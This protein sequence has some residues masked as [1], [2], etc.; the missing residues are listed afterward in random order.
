MKVSEARLILREHGLRQDAI[1]KLSRWEIVAAVRTLS[2]EKTKAGEGG[3]CK[4]S[5]INS[6]ITEIQERYMKDCQ[7]IFELQ[8][9][10]LNSAQVLSTDDD[11]STESED[12]D[13]EELGRNLEMLLSEN[14]SSTQLSFE[15]E[16]QERRELLEWIDD[17]NKRELPKIKEDVQVSSSR[18]LRLTRTIKDENGNEFSRVEIVRKPSVIDLY[19]KIRTTK[20][21]KFIKHYAV[22][23]EV[24]RQ[25]M[26]RE[27][28]NIMA[29]LR[30]IKKNE[31][32]SAVKKSIS[33]EGMAKQDVNN[34]LVKMEADSDNAIKTTKKIGSTH[35]DYLEYNR[36]SKRARKNPIVEFSQI[37]DNIL[38]ELTQVAQYEPFVCPVSARVYGYSYIVKK[39]MDIQSMR[40][41]LRD[42]KYSC[43]AEFLADV[44]QIVD[45]SKLFNGAQSFLTLAA[46]Q[47]LQNCVDKL[48]KQE[49]QLMLLELAI[50]SGESN[51][52]N[53]SNTLVNNECIIDVGNEGDCTGSMNIPVMIYPSQNLDLSHDGSLVDMEFSD[54]DEE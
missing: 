23:D 11:D 8:N 13:F 22:Q 21:D 25:A 36:T 45:N 50:D 37:C 24:I 41:K 2:T 27:K 30:T 32:I 46:E 12:S 3:L 1:K 53:S 44:V 26:R 54:T 17:N 18:I 29:Q 40:D 9:S 34:H 52:A 14:K 15:R 43:R 39:P 7:N 51:S 6:T 16:E 49:S 38:M 48:T 20:N 5:R 42:S 10:L 19:V 28:R 35:C 47:M 33:V 4:Y 31:E